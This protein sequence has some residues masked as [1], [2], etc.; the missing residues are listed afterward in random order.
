MNFQKEGQICSYQSSTFLKTGCF[1][2]N[3]HSCSIERKGKGQKAVS[4]KYIII[5]YLSEVNE[6]Q[7]Q[8]LSLESWH[9]FRA[10]KHYLKKKKKKKENK[11]AKYTRV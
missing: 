6:R 8:G 9:R 10:G 3:K 1:K 11:I 2:A 5:S 7:L 4:E